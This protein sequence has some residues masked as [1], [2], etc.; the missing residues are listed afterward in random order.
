[1]PCVLPGM[2]V[3]WACYMR[4]FDGWER[5]PFLLESSPARLW[6]ASLSHLPGSLRGENLSDDLGEALAMV[7]A[8][9]VGTDLPPF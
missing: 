1:V 7:E 5:R 6:G 9:Q 8:L 2:G 4:S 3:L